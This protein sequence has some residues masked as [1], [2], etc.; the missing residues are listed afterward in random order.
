M[1]ASKS[2]FMNLLLASIVIVLFL[3]AA[4]VTTVTWSPLL[5]E[6]IIVDINRNQVDEPDEF[7]SYVALHQTETWH[8]T[9]ALYSP[10]KI[11]DCVK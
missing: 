4:T 6:A 1:D 7:S 8:Y 5:P 3:I 10:L 11:V 2:H 9:A